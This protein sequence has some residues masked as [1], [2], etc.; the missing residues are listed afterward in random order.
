MKRK[1]T[2]GAETQYLDA[3]LAFQL[4]RDQYDHKKSNKAHDKLLAAAREI[5]LSH[6]DEGRKFF[7]ELVNHP[8]AH[9]R[10]WACFNLLPL[11]PEIAVNGLKQIARDDT[12]EAGHDAEM[13]LREWSN[14]NLDP[15][16]FMK[17][18]TLT[19]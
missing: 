14:G 6:E 3:A 7:K 12:S 16:W 5:R 4:A 9:V 19:H 15:N 11:E 2:S 1:K 8:M 13:T 18:P 17:K 10:A